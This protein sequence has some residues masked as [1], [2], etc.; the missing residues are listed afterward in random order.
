MYRKQLENDIKYTCKIT[1]CLRNLINNIQI[2]NHPTI[3]RFR[4]FLNLQLKM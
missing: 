3:I 1:S 2:E 4:V